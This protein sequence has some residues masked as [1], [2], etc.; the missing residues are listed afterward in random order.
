MLIFV[1]LIVL[2]QFAFDIVIVCYLLVFLFYFL[3]F[4]H[5]LKRRNKCIQ[6]Y[7]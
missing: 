4:S 6:M 2:P 1:R 7:I 5:C 3:L